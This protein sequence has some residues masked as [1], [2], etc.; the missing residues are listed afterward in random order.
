MAWGILGA[1]RQRLLAFAFVSGLVSLVYQLMWMRSLR[2]VFGASTAANAVAVAIFMGGLGLGGLYFGR[3]ADEWSTPQRRYAFIEA[4]IGVSAMLTVVLVYP[5]EWAYYALGGTASLGAAGATLVRLVLSVILLGPPTVLM[6]GTL[7]ALARLITD[8]GDVDRRAIGRL[9]GANTLGALTGACLGTFYTLELLGISRSLLAAGALNL[10]LAVVVH[11]TRPL[12]ERAASAHASNGASN[13]EADPGAAPPSEPSQ[14]GAA[15]E[16]RGFLLA[17]AAIVGFGFFAMEMVW[18]RVLA[19]LLG[20]SSYSFGVIL[21]LALLGIGL[22]GLLY[23]RGEGRRRPSLLG[24]GITC[25]LEAL[26]IAAP[27]A[28][29]D[30]LAILAVQV[31][32]L[33]AFGFGG[34]VLGWSLIA[35]LAVLPAAIIAGFQFPYLLALVGAGKRGVARDVGLVYLFNT[36]GSVVGAAGSGLSLL[37]LVG[38]EPL[39]RGLAGSLVLLAIASITLALT[40]HRERSLHD[41]TKISR[42]VLAG[43]V[44]VLA[45]LATFGPGPS[46]AWRHQPIGAGRVPVFESALDIESWRRESNAYVLWSEDGIESTFAVAS[47]NGYSMN[48]NGKSDGNAFGDGSTQV[49]LGLY[50]VLLHPDP[51]RALVIGLGTGST[52]GW[53]G[54]MEGIEHVDAVEFEPVVEEIVRMC[55]PVNY[56]VL[57][58]PKVQIHYGDAREFLTV[59]GG[60]YD[61]VVSEPSNPYRAGVASLFSRDYYARARARMADGGLFVQWV[62]GY[63]VDHQTLRVVMATLRDVFPAVE[64]WAVGRGDYAL[65]AYRDGAPIHDVDRIERR[66]AAG[67]PREALNATFLVDGAPGFF[68]SFVAG[69]ALVDSVYAIDRDWVDTDDAPVLEFGF[70]RSVG[71]DEWIELKELQQVAGRVG[72]ALPTVKDGI[73]WPA[74]EEARQVRLTVDKVPLQVLPP[75][76]GDPAVAARFA[77]RSNSDLSKFLEAWD[78]QSEPPRH[79]GDILRLAEAVARDGDEARA[80]ALAER[81]AEFSPTDAHLI[82]TLVTLKG[83]RWAEART[84]LEKAFEAGRRDPWFSEP[85]FMGVVAAVRAAPGPG[86]QDEPTDVTSLKR[87]TF[88]VLGQPLAVGRLQQ[89]RLVTRVFMA[90]EIDFEGLCIEAFESLEP[91]VPFDRKVLDRRAACYAQ[92]AHRRSKT[93]NEEFDWYVRMAGATTFAQD[94]G[95]ATVDPTTPTE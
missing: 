40:R 62:Q 5:V 43:L 34:I 3:Y 66:L 18:Y 44:V 31:Q 65:V 82:A 36:L 4:A 6:G 25:G 15:G 92:H 71:R 23:G 70:A 54:A 68:S 67:V 9:Y 51:K 35:G 81:L 2:L 24:F 46:S 83:K 53:I 94:I 13:G 69:P 87:E 11:A 90:D 39:W 60:S 95:D 73:D 45:S 22:G 21:I 86:T 32:P 49:G 55:Q 59:N 28:F 16:A 12:S 47:S 27:L 20:G 26:A 37:H 58:N 7:P 33:E 89:W 75:P 78:E 8:E 93:A 38:A 30:G 84:H 80:L 48:N 17:A 77:A 57:A 10:L 64:V 52:A 72:A 41:A 42:A 61:I 79:R 14:G 19:P 1:V 56:D 50:G 85:L 88:H 91:W 76:P 74:V 29:G 63:E